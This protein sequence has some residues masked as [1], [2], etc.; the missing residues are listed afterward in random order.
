M[1]TPSSNKRRVKLSRDNKKIQDGVE[2]QA[3]LDLCPVQELK[4]IAGVGETLKDYGSKVSSLNF[5]D[6]YIKNPSLAKEE[7]FGTFSIGLQ[8][9]AD[10]K[11]KANNGRERCLLSE[12]H[13]RFLR[14]VEHSLMNVVSHDTNTLRVNV[15]RGARTP[16]HNDT[17]RGTTNN[18]IMMFP[19]NE[20]SH[21][22][23]EVDMKVHFKC[24][25]VSIAH[26]DGFFIP[27]HFSEV[28]Q[29]IHM[30]GAHPTKPN[31]CQHYLFSSS[32][33]EEIF[34]I[35]LL[36]FAVMGIKK[37]RLQVVPLGMDSPT[38][39]KIIASPKELDLINF[40]EA[41]LKGKESNY[42]VPPRKRYRR[43]QKPMTW[44]QFN[45]WRFR[46]RWFADCSILRIHA[47][48][49]GIRQNCPSGHLKKIEKWSEIIYRLH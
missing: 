38:N 20:E 6:K 16:Y 4:L 17:L 3:I 42:D 8:Y 18:F 12:Q 29:T 31:Q 24:S 14:L 32:V 25:I 34:T 46:H 33:Y 10:F 13:I 49:R 35:G 11:K 43:L 37:G 30:V 28:K 27:L 19:P 9:E 1:V 21:G 26:Y 39:F 22:G 48:F 36:P 15:I 45:A 7:H 44:H 23:I 41:I 2:A 5:E 40:Q 47:Y